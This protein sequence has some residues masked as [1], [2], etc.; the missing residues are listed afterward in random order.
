MEVLLIIVI[1]ISLSMDAFSLSLAYGTLEIEKKQIYSLGIIVGAFHFF[2]PLI[3]LF[4]GNII[5]NI[6]KIN[7]NILVTIVLSII[8]LEMIY[9]SFK[10]EETINK[11]KTIERILFAFAV[12]IDSLTLGVT[13]NNITN[14][15]LFAVTTFSI[16]SAFFT[17][18]GLKLGKIIKRL[19]GKYS[20][21]LGGLILIT[22]G[23]IY[24]I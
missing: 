10:E 20:T 18:L 24:I 6:I 15:Y 3:G 1:S 7:S 23:I 16:T 9:E 2:M 11:M 4:I 22:I 19:I 8:G 5:F 21:I 12:S 14:N 13:L 17:I